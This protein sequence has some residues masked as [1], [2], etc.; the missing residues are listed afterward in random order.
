ME[1]LEVVCAPERAAK[2]TEAVEQIQVWRCF[3]LEQ[4]G[5]A[6]VYD[7]G[8]HLGGEAAPLLRP[9]LAVLHSVSEHL[10]LVAAPGLLLLL[11]LPPPPVRL[12]L[13]G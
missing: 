13:E 1:K 12:S 8:G 7:W 6:L 4:P 3:A 11:L 10:V 9:L 2:V 5:R